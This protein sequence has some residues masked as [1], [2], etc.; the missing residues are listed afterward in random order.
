M[1]LQK[2]ANFEHM[3]KKLQMK[4]NENTNW[5]IWS[6]YTECVSWQMVKRCVSISFM[7]RKRRKMK[8]RNKIAIGNIYG[9]KWATN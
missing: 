5:P 9:K 3:K 8:S 2:V 6:V 1:L 4:R 7:D